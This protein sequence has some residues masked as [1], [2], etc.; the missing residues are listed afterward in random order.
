MTFELLLLVIT[1]LYLSQIAL[2]LH[3][4]NRPRDI[5]TNM[6]RSHVSVIVAAR[7]E[8]ANIRRCLDSLF[9]QT[10][11]PD[12][13]EVI[14]VDDHSADGTGEICR[15]YMSTYPNMRV[16]SPPEG[17]TLLGKAN[18]LAHGIDEARG[19]IILITD[20]DC[21]VPETWIESTISR[22]EPNVGIVGGMTLQKANSPFE[23]MQSLDW[24]YLLGVAAATANLKNPLSTIGNNLSFR[25]KAYDDVGG[26]RKIKFSVTED[27]SLFQAIVQTGKWEYLYPMDPALLVTSE[28]CVRFKDLIRQKHRWGKG[29]LDM[30][31]AGFLIMGIGFLQHAA[32]ISSFFFDAATAGALALLVKSGGDYFFLERI[33]SRLGR[34]DQLRFFYWFELYYLFYVILLPFVVFFGGKVVWKGRSY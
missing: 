4:I 30:K 23:G 24:A 26:Y 31:I 14:V 5:T 9:R 13:F 6:Q 20:A 16:S 19:E 28:P 1:L 15:S 3:G 11:P 8:S 27:Y 7:N 29:G 2:L 18:A 10:Y 25:R 21:V 33:L 34:K 32:V 17:G 12:S 22:Y